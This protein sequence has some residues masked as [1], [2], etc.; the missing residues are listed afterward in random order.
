MISS[1]HYAQV[2]SFQIMTTTL[3]SEYKKQKR[4]TALPTIVRQIYYGGEGRSG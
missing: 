4:H 3:N 1:Q 2:N